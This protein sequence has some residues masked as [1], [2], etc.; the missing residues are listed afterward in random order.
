MEILKKIIYFL[1]LPIIVP[2]ALFVNLTYEWWMS[3]YLS[4]K[5]LFFLLS[6]VYVPLTLL[7]WGIFPWW[8]D[9]AA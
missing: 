3:I 1:L 9:L 8:A 5:I 6:P 4:R 7:M 2:I